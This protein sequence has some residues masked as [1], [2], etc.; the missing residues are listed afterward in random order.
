MMGRGCAI[1]RPTRHPPRAQTSEGWAQFHTG[2][3]SLTSPPEGLLCA[4]RRPLPAHRQRSRVFPPDL[5]AG[6]R[7]AG[8]LPCFAD[9]FPGESLGCCGRP[10][11]RIPGQQKPPPEVGQTDPLGRLLHAIRGL[12]LHYAL[13]RALR[14]PLCVTEVLLV[15]GH[16]LPLPDL[17]ELLPRPLFLTDHVPGR[18]SDGPRLCDRLQDGS[19][20]AEHPGGV[21]YPGANRRESPRQHE[22][23]VRRGEWNPGRKRHLSAPG[24]AGECA[25]GVCCRFPGPWLSLFP[26]LFGPFLGSERA[27]RTIHPFGEDQTPVLCQSAGRPKPQ[28]LHPAPCRFLVGIAGLPACPGN[29]CLL[30]HSC[31]W[32][33]WELPASGAHHVGGRLPL[34]PCVAVVPGKVWEEVGCLHRPFA[35]H[36]VSHCYHGRDP[37]LPGLRLHGGPGR[38]QPRRPLLVA[39]VHASRRSG[40]FQAAEPHLPQPG[41]FLLL[42]LCFLQ[43]ARRRPLPWDFHHEFAFC[44]LQSH[45][46]HT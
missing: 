13:V 19:G 2:E 8:A 23:E 42:V 26:F 22:E 45:G 20:D 35:D 27:A 37:Q 10:R 21:G 24:C 6:C 39:M 28:L 11:H 34:H 1:V 15:F 46:L 40:R 18:E 30:L 43:Q 16:V 17:H 14:F 32:T 41:S 7:A 9:P 31:S 36:P 44:R 25:H 5:L 33:A 4:W 38:K 29:L 12:L 3:T